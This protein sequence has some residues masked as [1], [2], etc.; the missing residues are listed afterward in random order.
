[1]RLCAARIVEIKWLPLTDL[2]T[3]HGKVT[4]T[5]EHAVHADPKYSGLQRRLLDEINRTIIQV[6]GDDEIAIAMENQMARTS[7]FRASE[8]YRLLESN[9]SR[10]LS[11]QCTHPSCHKQFSFLYLATK[12]QLTK[13]VQDAV[14]TLPDSYRGL[15]VH[16]LL[17][18]ATISYDTRNPN[19]S[20]LPKKS[21]PRLGL[22]KVLLENG[23]NPIAS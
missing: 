12:F 9:H 20:Y 2:L 11:Q 10:H 4:F 3:L 18:V 23:A 5:L 7:L 6:T 22:I 8:N 15:Y 1:M 17:W 19:G 16:I 13:F 14:T 21:T